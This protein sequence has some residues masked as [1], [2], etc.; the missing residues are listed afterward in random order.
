MEGNIVREVKREVHI[1]MLLA[2]SNPGIGLCWMG[3][4]RGVVS[5]E[6]P[7]RASW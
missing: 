5:G 2:G 4:V 1:F 6:L 7:N 3:A